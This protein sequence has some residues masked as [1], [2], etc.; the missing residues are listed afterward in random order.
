MTRLGRAVFVLVGAPFVLVSCSQASKLRGQI[1]GL[2]KIVEQAERNGA[3]RC[4]PRE[5][6]IA[7][8]QLKFASIELDQGF[9]SKAQAHL[10]KAESNARAADFLSPPEYCA[11]RGSRSTATATLSHI[12]DSAAQFRK[13]PAHLRA[14][15]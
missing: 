7:R 3:I 5:L 6:A 11:K 12:C 4:A 14:A 9:V 10:A 2:D 8:S 13:R 15:M 1:V